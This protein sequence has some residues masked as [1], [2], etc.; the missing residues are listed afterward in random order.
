MR[1]SL[2]RRS[3]LCLR[4]RCR[5]ACLSACRRRTASAILSVISSSC[6]VPIWFKSN[7]SDTSSS[8]TCRTR[9]SS[10][11]SASRSDELSNERKLDWC[12]TALGGLADA[13]EGF[14]LV[15]CLVSRLARES[16]LVARL[17]SLLLRSRDGRRLLLLLPAMPAS[18]K[19][20][21]WASSNMR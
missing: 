21:C 12:S 19:L 10:T 20:S 14:L 17:L 18:L 6:A 15:G 4:S 16:V 3:L 7:P 5:S 1:P 8:S 2:A 13:A 9:S 11:S